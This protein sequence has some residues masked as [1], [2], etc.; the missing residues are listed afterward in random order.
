M[1]NV[2][3]KINDAIDL[4]LKA[5]S[6]DARKE[7]AIEAKRLVEAEVDELE[8]SAG[9]TEELEVELES[10][11]DTVT[12]A[13]HRLLDEVQRPVGTLTFTVPKSSAVDQALLCLHD[14]I[15]RGL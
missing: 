10:R 6:D 12:T 9:Y 11:S 15:G 5:S 3:E 7:A 14:A 4:I 8:N 2:A 1:S 13:V